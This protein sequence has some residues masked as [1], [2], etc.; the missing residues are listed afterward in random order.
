MGENSASHTGALSRLMRAVC[1]HRFGGLE[2][3]VYE[4]VP[5]PAPARGQVLV[6]VKTAGVGPW[7]A[8]AQAGKSAVPQP[9]PLLKRVGQMQMK[10]AASDQCPQCEQVIFGSL[11]LM[12]ATSFPG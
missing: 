11:L 6:R 2:A 9:L 4:E 12:M 1:V 10:T 5:R 3:I 7:D 8:W